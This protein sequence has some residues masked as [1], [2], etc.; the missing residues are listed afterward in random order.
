M[1]SSVFSV[2]PAVL[3]QRKVLDHNLFEWMSYQEIV[4]LIVEDGTIPYELVSAACSHL[5]NIPPE[6]KR[7]QYSVA[8][9]AHVN[10]NP[11]ALGSFALPTT[12]P[13]QAPV[14][15][16]MAPVAAPAIPVMQAPVF[17][18]PTMPAPQLPVMPPVMAAPVVEAKYWFAV[19]GTQ[20]PPQLLTESQAKSQL[21]A[22]GDKARFMAEAGGDW[23]T[24]QQMGWGIASP[25]APPQM[26]PA[27]PSQPVAQTG[28]I[29]VLTTDVPFDV[30]A[31]VQFQNAPAVEEPKVP[32]GKEYSSSGD[33][34]SDGEL[35]EVKALRSKMQLNAA[36]PSMEDI[37]RLMALES[38]ARKHGQALA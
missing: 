5:A 21:T 29:E 10:I 30:P 2:E 24:P 12:A 33:M 14:L 26:P 16:T 34:L 32:L 18:V 15:P 3:A 28:N 35:A 20:N 19:I 22:V 36:P 11:A 38:R 9:P 25:A 13:V 27:F 8:N 7:V 31:N 1:G 23:K 6:K 17:N 37:T 4:D